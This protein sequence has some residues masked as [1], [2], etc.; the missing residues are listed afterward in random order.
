VVVV[1]VAPFAD[2][3]SGFG[4]AG[5]LLD[6]EQLVADAA[7]ERL[8]ERV[9]PRGAGLDERGLGRREATPVAQRV[10]G[11]LGAV[12]AAHMLRGAALAREAVQVRTV[13]SAVMLVATSIAKASRVNSSTML[14]SLIARPLTTWSNWKSR[15]RAKQA[16][17]EH[18]FRD[19]RL[20]DRCKERLRDAVG[21]VTEE[22]YQARLAA[23]APP[24]SSTTAAPTPKRAPSAR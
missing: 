15:R 16:R 20:T 4:Q 22:E 19:G 7:V 21:G 12:V 23:A 10:R 9:L 3:Y 8:N 11:Q 5:E 17:A 6:V 13:S 1:V 18:R 24:T 14:S 2:D